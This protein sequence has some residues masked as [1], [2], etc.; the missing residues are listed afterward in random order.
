MDDNDSFGD[1]EEEEAASKSKP[2]QSGEDGAA[3]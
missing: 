3:N 2:T 1:S